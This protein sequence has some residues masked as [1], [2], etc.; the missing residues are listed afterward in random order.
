VAGRRHLRRWRSLGRGLSTRAQS[1]CPGRVACTDDLGNRLNPAAFSAASS[2]HRLQILRL[3]CH[4]S[5][6]GRISKGFRS[7]KDREPLAVPVEQ[8]FAIIGRP[9]KREQVGRSLLEWSQIWDFRS[10]INARRGKSEHRRAASPLTAGRLSEISD[11]R[12]E[13]RSPLERRQVQQRTDQPT[14]LWR[15]VMGETVRPARA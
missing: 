11:F 2:S 3:S 5:E 9:C 6:F 15:G 7:L 14:A 13:I 10:E 4:S 8:G 1:L 12:F